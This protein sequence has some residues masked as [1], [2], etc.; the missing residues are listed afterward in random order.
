MVLLTDQQRATLTARLAEAEEA[1]HTIMTGGG[2]KVVVD[3]N[4]E[5]VE[6][7]QANSQRLSSYIQELKRQ[8]G[9]GSPAGPLNVWF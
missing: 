2:V 5:R 3:Q 4:G 9:A 8:L 7:Q 1:Y 6:Y